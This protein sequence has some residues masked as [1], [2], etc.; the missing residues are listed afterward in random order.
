MEGEIKFAQVALDV[1]P[2]K[3]N[4]AENI[5]QCMSCDEFSRY[6][7]PSS[8]TSYQMTKP[9]AP[10]SYSKCLEWTPSVSRQTA[11]YHAAFSGT[12]L[13]V[14]ALTVVTAA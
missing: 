4:E 1:I 2:C 14:L 3:K 7:S 8:G 12:C 11:M 9:W 10:H 6:A 13:H 5:V